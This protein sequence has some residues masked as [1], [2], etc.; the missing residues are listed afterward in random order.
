MEG[1]KEE[2]KVVEKGRKKKEIGVEREK[3]AEIVGEE[4]DVPEWPTVTIGDWVVETLPVDETTR[5]RRGGFDLRQCARFTQRGA[6]PMLR[7]KDKESTP[8]EAQ[9]SPS[10]GNN[11]ESNPRGAQLDPNNP[12]QGN[13]H[14]ATPQCL[15]LTEDFPVLSSDLLLPI[16]VAT[17]HAPSMIASPL[18]TPPTLGLKSQ[19]KYLKPPRQQAFPSGHP[20]PPP[21]TEDVPSNSSNSVLVDACSVLLML[22]LDLSPHISRRARLPCTNSLYT[23]EVAIL[24]PGLATPDANARRAGCI[25]SLMLIHSREIPTAHRRPRRRCMRRSIIRELGRGVL[26][27]V[28]LGDSGFNPSGT[29]NLGG[30]DWASHQPH[31]HNRPP[32]HYQLE[33]Q[34]R[35]H[36]APPAL[37]MTV[38]NMDPLVLRSVRGNNRS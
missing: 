26:Q 16:P 37:L 38:K 27:D 14:I 10:A 28:R 36:L 21:R 11:P 25:A 29:F 18:C 13:V 2:E 24:V 1:G 30:I 31:N 4:G 19:N 32:P 8:A 6:I 22:Q 35:L 15:L 5:S 23:R 12:L 17:R 7:R 33:T 20:P 34:R 9:K 3:V